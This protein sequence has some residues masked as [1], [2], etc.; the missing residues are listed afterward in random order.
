MSASVMQA[1]ARQL[2][3]AAGP[4]AASTRAFHAT[5]ASRGA[6]GYDYLH[7]KYMY[8]LRFKPAPKLLTGLLI[9]GGVATG[10]GIPLFAVWFGQKKA[11]VL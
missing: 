1:A 5:P 4:R 10:V 3:R 2:S 11:G 7:A 8:Q 9:G 6:G